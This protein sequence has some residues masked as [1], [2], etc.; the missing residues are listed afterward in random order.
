MDLIH[1]HKVLT[2]R[3][4][5]NSYRALRHLLHIYIQQDKEKILNILFWED[6][7][8]PRSGWYLYVDQYG[9]CEDHWPGIHINHI[10]VDILGRGRWDLRTILLIDLWF[11]WVWG[12]RTLFQLYIQ[13]GKEGMVPVVVLPV[14]QYAHLVDRMS[15]L[16]NPQRDLVILI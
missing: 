15:Q 11:F 6:Q 8:V 3:I 9:S 4:H 14:Y 7:D 2:D 13:M 10:G 16:H 5:N 1:H 12:I